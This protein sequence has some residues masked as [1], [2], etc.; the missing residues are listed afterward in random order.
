MLQAGVKI[1]NL[2]FF[3]YFEL[4]LDLK[5]Q[6]ICTNDEWATMDKPRKKKAKHGENPPVDY[7][8]WKCHKCGVSYDGGDGWSKSNKGYWYCPNCKKR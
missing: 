8:K 4:G 2:R 1:D 5:N 7:G 3:L 6:I